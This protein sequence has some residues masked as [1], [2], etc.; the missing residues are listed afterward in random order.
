MNCYDFDKTIYKKDSAIELLKFAMKQK[1]S[2]FFYAF[3]IVFFAV[4]YFCKFIKIEKFKEVYFGFLKFF[5]DKNKLIEEFWV[6]EEKNI[7]EWYIKQMRDDDVI[8]SASPLILIDSIM[9]KINPNCH[10]FATNL[11]IETMKI[12]GKNLK[13][14]NKKVCLVEA[15][16]EKFDSAYS[17]SLS[18]FPLYDMAENKYFVVGENVYEFGK[19]KLPIH[20]KFRYIIKELRVKHYIKNGL[21]FLPLIFSGLLFATGGKY[22]LD[23]IFGFIAF[24]GVASII[25][26]IND[27]VDVKKDRKHI[28]KRKRPYAAFM[29]NKFDMISMF[30]ALLAE[31]FVVWFY[32]L[33]KNIVA[34]CVLFGYL[35]MN[36]LYSF[37]LKNLPVIDIFILAAC[38][39]VRVYFGAV[40]ID[41]GVS[42]W[43]Y[44]TI[45]CA[46]LYLGLG[47]RRGDFVQ[48]S[49]SE[50]RKVNKKYSYEFL[51]KNMSMCLT[52]CVIFYALWIVEYRV[53]SISHINSILFL[54]SIP[55]VIFILMKYSLNIEKDKNSGDPIE[56]FLSDF[57]LIFAVLA[58]VVVLTLAIYIPIPEVIKGVLW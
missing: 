46:S 51:D 33:N 41:V 21:L 58:F 38:Y 29:L 39:V 25:Y 48:D 10:V 35:V 8:C 50:T 28:K 22:F 53:S 57:V 44:L 49:K 40:I 11:D 1:M 36:L 18:D 7:N 19:Q 12:V 34:L 47:K 43:L 3:K 37:W 26:L 42:K 15:G 23:C 55:L 14:E 17:D 52:M 13:G 27:F 16:Y 6:K 32:C 31:V 56:V 24:S 54:A 20:K 9:H 30:I 4:L 5:D 2:V 45:I